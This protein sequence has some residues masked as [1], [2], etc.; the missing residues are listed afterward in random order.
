MTETREAKTKVPMGVIA[1]AVINFIFGFAGIFL[2]ILGITLQP[3]LSLY[4]F[5]LSS[6]LLVSGLGLL[7]LKSWAWYLAVGASIISLALYPLLPAQ[8]FPLEIL[9]LPYLVWKREI[10]GI[11]LG[12]R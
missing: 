2:G 1:V 4:I 8:G 9:V 10:F 3:F 5:V 12:S 11:K 7:E 6:I